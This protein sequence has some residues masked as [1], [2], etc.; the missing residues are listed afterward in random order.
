MSS[1][2]KVLVIDDEPAARETVEALLAGEP[3]DLFLAANGEEGLALATSLR[4]DVVL[5]DVM[6]PGMDGFAVCRRL[7]ADPELAPVPVVMVTAL[8][9]R[10]SRLEGLRAGADDFLAKPFDSLELLAR[11]RTIAQLNR[12]RRLLEERTTFQWMT[13]QSQDGYVLLDEGDQ[14]LFANRQ[15]RLYLNLPEA[16]QELPQEPFLALVRRRYRCEPE[17]A[18]RDWPAPTKPP[19]F[20][21]RYLVLPESA[22]APALWLLVSV[23]PQ[24][25]QARRLLALRDITAQ[26]AARRD[27]RTFHAMLH[28]KLRTPLVTL[29]GGLELLAEG[30]G[31][32][33][34][35][36]ADVVQMALRGGRRLHATIEDI[37]HYLS[38]AKLQQPDA[39][40]PLDRLPPLAQGLG[41]T[42]E[43]PSL[44]VSVAPEL[45]G[46]ATV[47]S[48]RTVEWL[49]LEL[50]EN[51]RK[52][53]P[54]RKPAVIVSAAPAGAEMVSLRVV[55]DG[56][57]LSPEQLAHAFQPYYQGEKSFTG[58]VVG[59]GLG[60]ASVAATV[61]QVGGTC[62]LRNREPGPGVEAEMVLPLAPRQLATNPE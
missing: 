58:E 48:E 4:P 9:D 46:T 13:E 26:L 56:V 53:H 6:M 55:D 21:A 41:A 14:I 40:F 22:T 52:F 36:D 51:S 19:D 2:S 29:L 17:E 15:A 54:Q 39:G 57:T 7:R 44:T 16:A 30:G 3:Y 42:L 50:L 61:W 32:S 60:L 35:E 5:L 18:W 38:A 34:A 23:L 12:Y 27:M 10:D 37:L 33:S 45:L 28:H 31:F 1:R 25:A 43:L 20:G 62:H 47:L 11:L 8:D 59:M 49:L 24:P